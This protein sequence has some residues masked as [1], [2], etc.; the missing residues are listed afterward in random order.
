MGNWIII[1]SRIDCEDTQ[2]LII[3]VIQT[4]VGALSIA[5]S[6]SLLF[7]QVSLGS[8]SLRSSRIIFEKPFFKILV[9]ISVFGISLLSAIYLLVEDTSDLLP[10]LFAFLTIFIFICLIFLFIFYLIST[11]FFLTPEDII[12]SQLRYRTKKDIC[13]EGINTIQSIFYEERYLKFIEFPSLYFSES[14]RLLLD[15][16][17]KMISTNDHIALAYTVRVILGFEGAKSVP[18]YLFDSK[19]TIFPITDNYIKEEKINIGELSV[20]DIEM[21]IFYN[22]S[23]ALT[24]IWD[25]V[26]QSNDKI[27]ARFIVNAFSDL[28]RTPSGRIRKSTIDKVLLHNFYFERLLKD[29]SS[30]HWA[31]LHDYV[32]SVLLIPIQIEYVEIRNQFKKS[33]IG[34]SYLLMFQPLNNLSLYNNH[35]RETFEIPLDEESEEQLI[36]LIIAIDSWLLIENT[37][38]KHNEIA[39]E[40]FAELSQISIINNHVSNLSQAF[41]HL[42]DRIADVFKNKMSASYILTQGIPNLLGDLGEFW[43]RE[44]SVDD[45][46]PIQNAFLTYYSCILETKDIS[47]FIRQI[48]FYELALERMATEAIKCKKLYYLQLILNLMARI[49]VNWED[50]AIVFFDKIEH[51]LL[52]SIRNNNTKFF[53]HYSISILQFLNDDRSIKNFSTLGKFHKFYKSDEV[54]KFIKNNKSFK[55]EYTSIIIEIEKYLPK[56]KY[57]YSII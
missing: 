9:A 23:T 14:M 30:S 17:K 56:K 36:E 2:G 18:D 20:T 34:N 15:F 52:M 16:A 28:I 55:S 47:G 49:S 24:Y 37:D 43:I 50:S 33:N 57:L 6:F 4:L 1:V 53:H 22:L 32:L 8:Y 29:T 25:L 45:I 5:I 54:K 39:F 42:S 31:D 3:G 35:E 7:I 27:S 51:F 44:N 48:A 41:L 46:R 10:A 13:L 11:V 26:I 19:L 21:G 40:A 38:S 12:K